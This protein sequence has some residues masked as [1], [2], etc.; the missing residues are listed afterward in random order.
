LIDFFT[1]SLVHIKPILLQL[2]DSLSLMERCEDMR[3][4]NV[5][6]ALYE[7]QQMGQPTLK[8]VRS[9]GCLVV[10]ISRSALL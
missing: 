7:E 5:L 1:P 2:K 10:C 9:F 6:N 3:R 4:D 8:L